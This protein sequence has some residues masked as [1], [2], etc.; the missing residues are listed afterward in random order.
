MAEQTGEPVDPRTL[1]KPWRLWASVAIGG[2]VALGALFA[3][4]IVPNY[5]RENAGVTLWVAICRSIG[6][7]EGSPAY[8]QPSDKTTAV[9]V[10]QVRWEPR[11][12]TLLADGKSARGAQVASEV[13]AACHGERGVSATAEIPSLAGQTP[14]AI[15]KQLNDYRTGSRAHAQ[16]TQLARSLSEDDLANVAAYFGHVVDV[17][18]LGARDQPAE[19]EIVRIAKEGDPRRRLPACNSCHVNGAGGPLETPVILGQDQQYLL[20]Q[21]QAF[22]SGQ[23]QN[24]VYGR[25]R[26]IARQLSEDEMLAISRYYQGVI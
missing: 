9:P 5:Q 20:R 21:L 15:Y 2:F 4:L 17:N 24:D 3:F 19:P 12:L 11:V 18:G 14:A 22:R 26:S 6:V 7:A 1:D 8:P 13:C 23:R 16:M 10:S 25:M